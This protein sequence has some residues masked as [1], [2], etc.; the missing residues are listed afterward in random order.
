[1]KI[2]A[3]HPRK[4]LNVIHNSFLL[5]S[6]GKKFLLLQSNLVHTGFEVVIPPHVAQ[7]RVHTLVV[8]VGLHTFG[9][10]VSSAAHAAERWSW[11]RGG[12]R[13]RGDWGKGS[14]GERV[15]AGARMKEGQFVEKFPMRSWK[16]RG[17]QPG[18]GGRVGRVH[19]GFR[20]G[21]E[22]PKWNMWPLCSIPWPRICISPFSTPQPLVPNP[23]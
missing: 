22:L 20:G 23:T 11:G 15:G 13:R 14:E 2:I 18:Y 21:S 10:R 8:R 7:L 12:R 5:P 17:G 6:L 16:Y 3:L 4:T 19:A 9:F 1:M